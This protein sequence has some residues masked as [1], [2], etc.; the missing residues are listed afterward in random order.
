MSLSINDVLSTTILD[1]YKLVA[2]KGHLNRIVESISLLE[3][4]DFEKYVKDRALILTTLYPI[5][6]NNEAIN[7]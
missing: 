5:Q 2:G 3:T 1:S 7:F 6:S 4:P